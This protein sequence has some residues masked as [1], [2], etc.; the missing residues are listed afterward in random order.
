MEMTTSISIEEL[1]SLLARGD[2]PNLLDV[3]RKADYEGSP[4]TIPGGTW[5]DPEKMDEW[6]ALVPSGRS[7]LVYCV[8]GGSVSRSVADQLEK[9]GRDAAF[10]EGGIRAWIERGEPVE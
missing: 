1:K 6:I 3:R 4:E 10:L 7:T 8:K 5:R 9:E 2:A